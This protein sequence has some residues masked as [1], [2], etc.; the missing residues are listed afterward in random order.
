MQLNAHRR[1]VDGDNLL[2]TL[3][4]RRTFFDMPLSADHLTRSCHALDDDTKAAW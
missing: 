3:L 1:G 4:A 2:K